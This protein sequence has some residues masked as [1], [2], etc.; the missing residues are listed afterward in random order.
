LAALPESFVGRDWAANDG[1]GGRAPP[2]GVADKHSRGEATRACLI[3]CLSLYSG[4][5]QAAVLESLM[6]GDLELMVPLWATMM[7]QLPPQ[8]NK[9]SRMRV[10]R[11]FLIACVFIV[12]GSHTGVR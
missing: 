6:S 11:S 3:E 10:T 7:A 2:G 5:W 9:N 8:I 1:H 4:F 12:A